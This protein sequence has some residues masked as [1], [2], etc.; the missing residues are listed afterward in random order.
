MT[1]DIAVSE[2]RQHY[3]RRAITLELTTKSQRPRG[4]RP[5]HRERL[6]M[7]GT[8]NWPGTR[9]IVIVV[10]YIMQYRILYKFIL[11]F[12]FNY[13]LFCSVTQSLGTDKINSEPSTYQIAFK[14]PLKRCCCAGYNW[15]H[16][17]LFI[18]YYVFFYIQQKQRKA[19]ARITRRRR[20]SRTATI[21]TATRTTK[22]T[23]R[24]T[25]GASS[26]PP[27]ATGIQSTCSV[28]AYSQTQFNSSIGPKCGIQDIYITHAIDL[29]FTCR[30]TAKGIIAQS[31]S[32]V[33]LYSYRL[34]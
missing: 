14:L 11:Q 4:T 10:S 30:S 1:K 22:S 34:R 25:S 31:I 13:Y 6:L 19:T 32:T 2:V 26:R 17:K 16:I 18:Y 8:P 27:P 24:R 9:L 3:G 7:Y 21:T 12:Q 29:H 15:P 20:T 33:F 23:T 28:S 5:P